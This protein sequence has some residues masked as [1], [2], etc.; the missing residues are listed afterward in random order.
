MDTPIL[1]AASFMD[2]VPKSQASYKPKSHSG[3]FS[4][5]TANDGRYGIER[6]PPLD[7]ASRADAL[8]SSS[9]SPIPKCRRLFSPRG[10]R[11]S[12]IV[13]PAPFLFSFSTTRATT[14]TIDDRR[15]STRIHRLRP[16]TNKSKDR[17]FLVFMTT[18]LSFHA[19]A[20]SPS[21]HEGDGFRGQKRMR[22]RLTRR[23]QRQRER[24]SVRPSGRSSR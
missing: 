9:Q 18:S 13:P 19:R 20:D 4:S 1:S 6:K 10:P 23:R 24:A 8:S 11:R 17:P 14:T 2:N 3:S 5:S 15:R 21:P 7:D 16:P 12:G 22:F